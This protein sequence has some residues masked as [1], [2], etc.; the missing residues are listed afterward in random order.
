MKKT[1]W[2]WGGNLSAAH[3]GGLGSIIPAGKPTEATDTKK[4]TNVEM[5]WCQI[6]K[7]SCCETFP[8][9]SKKSKTK[10]VLQADGRF[11]DCQ[12]YL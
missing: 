12:V 1:M 4:K 3:V 2:T 11:C 7:F 8:W 5:K 9:P 6:V 10:D